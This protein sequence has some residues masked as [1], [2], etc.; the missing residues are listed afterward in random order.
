MTNQDRVYDPYAEDSRY[1]AAIA[2]I[3]SRIHALDTLREAGASSSPASR[4]ALVEI[5]I[6]VSLRD[7]LETRSEAHAVEAA[8]VHNARRDV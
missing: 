2:V 6:L 5:E 4:N 7:D 8:N 1:D 3:G